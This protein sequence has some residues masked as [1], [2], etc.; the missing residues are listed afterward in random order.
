MLLSLLLWNHYNHKIYELDSTRLQEGN[1]IMF[2]KDYYF[3]VKWV[4]MSIWLSYLGRH[5][6]VG[7]DLVG[8]VI[9][10]IYLYRSWKWS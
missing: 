8:V 5:V 4:F 10:L 9:Y 7:F 3:R 2:Y 6:G 1:W